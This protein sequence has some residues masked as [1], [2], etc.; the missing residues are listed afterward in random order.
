MEE[1]DIFGASTELTT[2]G[3]DRQLS[4]YID[5]GQLGAKSQVEGTESERKETSEGSPASLQAA[6]FKCVYDLSTL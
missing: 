5:K 1:T 4:N 2:N 6:T 3:E